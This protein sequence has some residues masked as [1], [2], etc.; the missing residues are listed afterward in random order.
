MSASAKNYRPRSKKTKSAVVSL[1]AD[2]TRRS[3]SY[4]AALEPMF[5]PLPALGRREMIP[6]QPIPYQDWI[7]QLLGIGD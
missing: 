7:A 1:G 5:A 6:P 2:N 3:R 4:R